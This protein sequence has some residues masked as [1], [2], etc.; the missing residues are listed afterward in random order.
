MDRKRLRHTR[1][2]SED[3]RNSLLDKR[4]TSLFKKAEEFS[5]L[6]DVDVAIII[7]SPGENQPIVWRSRNMA[8]EVLMRYSNFPESERLKKLMKH[9][10]YISKKVNE[11]EENIRK[12]EKMNEE[13]EM[14]ILF[15]QVVEGKNI[16]ELSV[17]EIQGLLKLSSAIVAKLHQRKK[18]VNNQHQP[19]Q[20][21]ISLSN[22]TIVNENVSPLPNAMDD[23]NSDMWFVK[24]MSTNRNYFGTGDANNTAFAPAEGDDISAEDNGH[25]KGL[26]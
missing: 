10:M 9:E 21:Q 13:K 26:D 7:F 19:S 17:R 2:S 12:I 14:K 4:A 8:R 24:T 22:F 25:S 15:N 16:A 23:L 18:K 3:V 20:S 5:V 6:C 11:K 1:N